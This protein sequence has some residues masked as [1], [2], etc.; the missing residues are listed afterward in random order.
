MTAAPHTSRKATSTAV[1]AAK[2]TGEATQHAPLIASAV[3][4]AGERPKRSDAHP[5]SNTAGRPSDTDR[6]ERDQFR[7]RRGRVAVRLCPAATNIGQPGPHR[8]ELPHVPEV[9]E[10]G[11]AGS[12]FG[13][14]PH[15]VAGIRC[16]R[17]RAADWAPPDDARAT[18]AA[19]ARVT[20][21]RRHHATPRQVPRPP[22]RCGSAE[23]RVSAPIRTPKA[24][25]RSAGVDHDAMSF[26]STG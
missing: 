16:D 14:H 21:R 4:A 7:R 6:D 15:C 13:E 22:I 25:P 26:I 18:T 3:T 5:P 19:P 20:A 2:K 8:V 24:R 1:G 10:A 12:A 11:Q 17:A 9:T 23:P